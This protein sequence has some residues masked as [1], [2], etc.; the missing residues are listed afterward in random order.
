MTVIDIEIPH[1]T[2]YND[3]CCIFCNQTDPCLLKYVLWCYSKAFFLAL[4]F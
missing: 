2:L 3:L 4:R 1:V